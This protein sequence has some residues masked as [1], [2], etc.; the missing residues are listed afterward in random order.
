MAGDYLFQ[1]YWMATQKTKQFSALTIHAGFYACAV[2]V[3]S[4]PVGGLSL[5][6]V[7]F[8][9]ITHAVVDKRDVTLWWCKHVT[10]SKHMWLVI[11]TD[12]AVHIVVLALTCLLEQRIAGGLF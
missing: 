7:L 8:L 6:S 11:M 5:L 12:Q 1:T 4:L 9:F 3:T 10:R 2:W